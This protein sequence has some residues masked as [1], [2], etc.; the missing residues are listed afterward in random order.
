[1]LPGTL[2]PRPDLDPRLDLLRR[3]RRRQVA[4]RTAILGRLMALPDFTSDF[5][6]WYQAVVRDA[7]LAENSLV[8]GTMVIKPYGYAIWEAI[9]DALDLRFKQ[10]GHQNLYFPMFIPYSP[11]RAREGTRRRVRARG[12]GGHAR[13]WRGARRAAGRASDLRDDHLGH[14]FAMGA[15]LSRPAAALQPVGERRALGAPAAPV[16][17]DDRVPVA[18]GPHRARDARGGVG[19][20][21]PHARGLSAGRRGRDG[22][23]RPHGPEDR[24]RAIPRRGRDVHDRGA[25]ARP[26][27]AAVRDVALPGHELREGLRRASSWAATARSTAPKRPR[28]ARPP[29]WWAA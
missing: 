24:E 12:R 5:P 7:E 16:P 26:Q 23:A 2:D 28:G 13:R 27:G 9:R 21:P 10:T 17:A 6:A 18:G 8:R 29:G 3:R 20:D 25:D 22:D 11:A 1:M 15:E 4:G 14:L 19:G